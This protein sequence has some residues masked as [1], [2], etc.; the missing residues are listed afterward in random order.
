MGG[1]I[2]G[3][4]NTEKGRFPGKNKIAGK[5]RSRGA[6]CTRGFRENVG[7]VPKSVPQYSA[8]KYRF[9]IAPHERNGKRAVKGTG[10]AGILTLG[11][12]GKQWNAAPHRNRR[13]IRKEL[14]FFGSEG[15]NAQMYGLLTAPDFDP[16]GHS[17][18]PYT[19]GLG[20][21]RGKTF[22]QK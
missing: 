10:E 5:G 15:S 7:A 4:F 14:R 13:D 17:D 19:L 2:G 6:P 11:T 3:L 22:W 21:L 9:G 16:L 12:L 20:C 1:E 18:G 8:D